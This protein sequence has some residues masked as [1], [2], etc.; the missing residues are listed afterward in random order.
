MAKGEQEQGRLLE[1]ASHEKY[2]IQSLFKERKEEIDRKKR[3]E[4]KIKIAKR[5]EMEKKK[6][7]EK[8]QFTSDIVMHGLWQ[9]ADE[10]V[11]MVS[12]YSS[13]TAKLSP[14]KLLK[15]NSFL[16]KKF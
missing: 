16:E 11:N 5:E 2:K 4:V 1:Q 6:L 15:H 10:V 13:L 14:L 12:S 3:E 9:T 7:R 8:E